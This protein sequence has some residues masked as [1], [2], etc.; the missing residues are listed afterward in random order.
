MNIIEHLLLV[1]GI[2]VLADTSILLYKRLH[3]TKPKSESKV[4]DWANRIPISKDGVDPEWLKL[5][6]SDNN[7]VLLNGEKYA[8]DYDT[9]VLRSEDGTE[10][11]INP[12][13]FK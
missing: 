6:L 11:T 5:R 2:L 9:H 8:L 1:V 10:Y 12:D 3:K 13:F 7:Y 4:I